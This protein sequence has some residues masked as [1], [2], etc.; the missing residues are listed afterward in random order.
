MF[1][2]E[3]GYELMDLRSLPQ[4]LRSFWGKRCVACKEEAE[5][6]TFRD[7]DEFLATIVCAIEY[8]QRALRYLQSWLMKG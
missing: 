8:L 1:S 3:I 4:D 2:G 6:G 7:L 5:N